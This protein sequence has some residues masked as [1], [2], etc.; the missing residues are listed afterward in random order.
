MAEAGDIQHPRRAARRFR[1]R[2][3][4]APALALLLLAGGPA[5][6]QPDDD[7]ALAPV[8]V[9]DDPGAG[10]AVG[11]LVDQVRTGRL[12]LAVRSA[13]ELLSRSPESL[14]LSAA[15]PDLHVT[16]RQRVHDLM[17][18]PQGAAFLEAYRQA[19]G[20]EAD[21]WFDQQR[22]A[23]LETSALFTPAGLR[24]ALRMAEAHLAAGRF[25]LARRTLESVKAHPD[26]SG[27]ARDLAAAIAAGV[28]G[29]LP[30]ERSA[31]LVTAL[32]G[33][34]PQPWPAP[35]ALRR[36]ARSSLTPGPGVAMQ[37]LVPRPLITSVFGDEVPIESLPRSSG[38]SVNSVPPFARDLRTYP[39]L[40]R[41]LA[42]VL[43]GRDLAAFDARTLQP[44]WRVDLVEA[45]QLENTP[46]G[47]DLARPDPAEFR[48]MPLASAED[49]CLAW[50]GQGDVAVGAITAQSPR[51]AET[52]DLIFG[53]D[54]GTGLIRWSLALTQID[55]T[56][57]NL[58]VRGPV[59]ID[60]DIT[61]ISC[62][63]NQPERRLA[64]LY[65]I[66]LDT[67][68]GRPRWTRLV[69]SAGVL[70]FRGAQQVTDGA[71]LADGLVF[72][73]DRLGVI[74]A[75]EAHTGRPA[76]VRR[77]PPEPA[78]GEIPSAPWHM[79]VPVVRGDTAY[80][81][82]PDRTSILAMSV[83]S[84]AIIARVATEDF[85]EAHYVLD[86]GSRLAAVGE[87]RMAFVPFEGFG[88]APPALTP[89]FDAPGI[90]G[91]AVVAGGEVLA[92]VLSPAPG[93]MV[94]KPESPEQLR[95]VRTDE[96]G[97]LTVT[98]DRLVVTDDARVHL[99]LRWEEAAALLRQRLRDNP[100][101]PTPAIR[102]VEF[103]YAAG[104]TAEI[105]A[106]TEEALR[107]VTGGEA[108][109]RHEGLASRLA[110]AVLAM[111]EASLNPARAESGA[112][113][114]LQPPKLPP[115]L[116]TRL[117]PLIEPA[118]ATPE[119]RA[120]RLILLAADQSSRDLKREAVASLQSVLASRDLQTAMF[121]SARGAVEA[122]GEATTRLQA[123]IASGGRGLYEPFDRELDQQIAALPPGAETSAIELLASR[124]PLGRATPGLWLR[125][126]DMHGGGEQARA[127]AKALELGL[128]AAARMPDPPETVVGELGG[129]LITNLRERGLLIA[130]G[131]QLRRLST[132]YPAVTLTARGQPLDRPALAQTLGEHM[133]TMRRWPS[134]GAPIQ[135]GQQ[136]LTGWALL[137]PLLDDPMPH[138]RPFFVLRHTSGKVALYGSA[139]NAPDGAPLTELALHASTD[140]QTVLV[141]SDPGGALLFLAESQS[142]VRLDTR[143][144]KAAWSTPSFNSMIGEP[145]PARNNREFRPPDF[146]E[147]RQTVQ[148]REI[149]FTGDEATLAMVQRRGRLVL[150]DAASGERLAA[151]KVDLTAVYDAVVIGGTLIIAGQRDEDGKALQLLLAYDTRTGG[152]LRTVTL[153]EEAGDV[154]WMRAS[155]RGELVVGAR[156][157]VMGFD[158]VRL[159]APV[160]MLTDHM[161][162][163]APDA[164]IVDDRL[165]IKDES[166]ELWLLDT[167]DGRVIAGP[168]DP[169]SRT[170]TGGPIYADRRTD[171]GGSRIAIRSGQGVL[172]LG[173][174]GS[175]IGTDAVASGEDALLPPVPIESGYFGLSTTRPEFA[176]NVIFGYTCF[177]LDA[178]TAAATSAGSIRLPREPERVAVIDGRVAVTYG[179]S[180]VVFNAP[181]VS[182]QP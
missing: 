20:P 91:R 25:S 49:L 138:S 34:P 126:A 87:N 108:K 176:V 76:W 70:P 153:P 123:L 158:P 44:R 107:L 23:D 102:L 59:L 113:A 33:V 120:T 103:A 109:A 5:L 112:V 171:A 152:L 168:I 159:E 72:R 29:A 35:E 30:D 135:E 64:A 95:L 149:L 82:S 156:Q 18:S 54:V 163:A 162:S 133:A 148:G 129:R 182:T 122:G 151:Q 46:A 21:G 85:A 43:N 78:Q 32:G 79:N 68:T 116:C 31:A 55:P 13:R 178:R 132:N 51:N 173:M 11:L 2:R 125:L 145:A 98:D 1:A 111:V 181:V 15:D 155:V 22:Y 110:G 7:A 144:G 66:G 36:P 80:L 38:A 61:V 154:R 124:F 131:E 57:S 150:L 179:F 27:P 86:A 161:A 42:I 164:W 84:G 128:R 93:L 56:F 3:S 92:P 77:L 117:L 142:V 19:A 10:E 83:R 60:N 71:V 96:P 88:T 104:K 9:N 48:R 106:A 24:G 94:V 89:A 50:A 14:V 17:T 67:F 39:M 115:E 165:I 127:E 63:K 143:T 121:R 180:T 166:A 139:A 26:L 136:V 52:P 172:L 40:Y 101:D 175:V 47:R 134:A 69:G 74:G 177:T 81:V 75:Y 97:A 73:S 8:F 174:D 160:W 90:R 170:M 119:Q 6:A 65:L 45:L 4:L 100:A 147:A 169:R 114:G 157:A 137:Q 140:R 167:A 53:F 41:G 130:A 146:I 118:C 105:G 99:Y 12:D 37:D 16:V 62:R 141:R 28:A 58:R